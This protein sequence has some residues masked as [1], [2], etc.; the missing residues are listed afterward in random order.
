MIRKVY[1]ALY[2]IAVVKKQYTQLADQ[3]LIEVSNVMFWCETDCST[4]FTCWNHIIFYWTI[5]VF[6]M[7]KGYLT[8]LDVQI[9]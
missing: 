6:T 7:K 4:F 8:Y 3:I 1:C 5:S 9:I 2:N